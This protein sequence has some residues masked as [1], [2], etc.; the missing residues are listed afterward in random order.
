MP[1]EKKTRPIYLIHLYITLSG[2]YVLCWG[3]E[4]DLKYK[5][6]SKNWIQ[7]LIKQFNIKI[8]GNMEQLKQYASHPPHTER[9]KDAK[10]TAKLN[11]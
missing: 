11:N 8:L 10:T 9:E 7:G 4:L 3:V 1:G 2:P 5:H 6:S